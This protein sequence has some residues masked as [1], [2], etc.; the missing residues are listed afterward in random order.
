MLHA[1]A[2]PGNPYGAHTLAGMIDATQALTGR[3]IERVYGD[4]GYPNRSS[5][6]LLNGQRSRTVLGAREGE[7][8]PRDSPF[9]EVHNTIMDSN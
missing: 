3:E 6:R 7:I 9:A 8:P 2:L 4:K 1:V 5:I